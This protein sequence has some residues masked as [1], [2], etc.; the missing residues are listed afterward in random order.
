M[1]MDVQLV[2]P[3][4]IAYSG[5]AEMVLCR[6]V[7]GGDIAFL[8]GHAPFIGALAVHPVTVRPPSG[9]DLVIAVHGGF[10]EVS[11]GKVVVLSDVAELPDAI[12][13]SRAQRAKER[14]EVA[15][16]ADPVDPEALAALSRAELRLA[17]AG[18]RHGAPQAAGAH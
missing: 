3:E 6:T 12:D 5:E 4:Q 2:S 1:P 8:P 11:G 17:V 10:V 13:A 18:E 7:D 9:A 15:L 16:R 14:A